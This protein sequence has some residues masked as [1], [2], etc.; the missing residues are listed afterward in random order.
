MVS[1]LTSHFK[2]QKR[3]KQ[4]NPEIGWKYN[5]AHETKASIFTTK[6]NSLQNWSE[7]LFNETSSLEATSA[8][9]N[10]VY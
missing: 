4:S 10:Q 2:K 5:E 9:V 1:L 6:E 7:G 8:K 3:E